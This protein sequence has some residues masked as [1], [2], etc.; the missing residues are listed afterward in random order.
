MY[1]KIQHGVVVE[2]PYSVGDLMRNNPSVSFP[3]DIPDSL[4]ETLGVMRAEFLPVVVGA[5]QCIDGPDYAIDDTRKRV[6]ATLR[7]RDM[8]KTERD[9][10]DA[11]QRLLNMPMFVAEGQF[12]AALLRAGLLDKVD[13]V[14]AALPSGEQ[15]TAKADWESK[16]PVARSSRFVTQL[17]QGLSMLEVEM[18]NLFISAAKNQT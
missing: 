15:T 5:Y 1:A 18:D 3:V 8:T 2:C 16:N 6:T 14:I 13:G 7:V 10:F 17:A 11:K 4:L 12:R 9:A